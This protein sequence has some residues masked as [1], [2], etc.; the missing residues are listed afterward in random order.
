MQKAKALNFAQKIITMDS[1]RNIDSNPR[2]KQKTDK[3]E[4]LTTPSS[5]LSIKDP[6]VWKQ[7]AASGF[8]ATC[9]LGRLLLLTSKSFVG[10]DEESVYNTLCW[11]HWGQ[12]TVN[13]LLAATQI[14]PMNYFQTLGPPSFN[15]RDDAPRLSVPELQYSPEDYIL[16]V[17]MLNMGVVKMLFSVAIS[18]EEVPEFFRDG[19]IETYA[20][21][22]PVRNVLSVGN[23]TKFS[24]EWHNL[25]DEH[26]VLVQLRLRA[27]FKLMRKPDRKILEI[28]HHDL[29]D[30]I[31]DL[32]ESTNK[33]Y[34]NSYTLKPLSDGIR[35]KDH[36][37]FLYNYLHKEATKCSFGVLFY[38][39]FE[40]AYDENNDTYSGSIDL[41]EIDIQITWETDYDSDQFRAAFIQE[42]QFAHVLEA[43]PWNDAPSQPLQPRNI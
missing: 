34:M 35:P 24:V 30:G 31:L 39:Y 43:L 40:A 19:K 23:G 5:D 42:V 38:V 4:V 1:H 37:S 13:A 8:L 18:G 26:D 11:N 33:F 9:D 7:L 6:R 3:K 16:I 12:D 2:K 17:E 10:H 15:N 14:P 21:K 20:L 28:A 27:N 41:T 22:N 25:F 32:Q 29:Q 36:V